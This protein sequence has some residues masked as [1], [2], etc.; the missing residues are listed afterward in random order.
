MVFFL[1]TMELKGQG[2]VRRSKR[3]SETGVASEV[4]DNL[5]GSVSP[6]LY[7]SL[8]PNSRCCA[9]GQALQEL[10]S[11]GPPDQIFSAAW[12]V[13][14]PADAEADISSEEE[15]E[16]VPPA[17]GQSRKSGGIFG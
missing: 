6:H 7:S 4:R 12:P 5:W 1:S 10:V 13:Q 2:S 15:R 16:E 8:V 11:G 14:S 17:M 9:S 3:V